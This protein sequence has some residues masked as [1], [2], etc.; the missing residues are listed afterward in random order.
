MQTIPLFKSHFSFHGRSILTLEEP[1][2]ITGKS[3]VSVFSIAKDHGLKE[4]TLVDDTMTGYMQA[5]TN[6]SKCGVKLIFGLRLTVTASMESKNE[7]SLKTDSKIAIFPKNIDG[8]E[9]L[10]RIFSKAAKDGFYYEPRIDY[11]NLAALWDNLNL[12][13]GIPF[14]DSFLFKNTLSYG[15]CVPDFSFT[16]PFFFTE[17]NGLPFD[18]IIKSKV[19][20]YAKD[21]YEVFHAKSIFYYQKKDFL[22]YL[23]YKCIN[24]RTTLE[25]PEF[26][27]MTSDLFCFESFLE[28]A[29]NQNNQ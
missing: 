15:L 29:K 25:K 23:T 4:L 13:L 2:P 16:E 8:Q 14:Y 22:A 1:A 10:Y 11:K 24:N 5:M 12:K 20:S 7:D 19:L 18:P 26:S 28:N 3:P 17:D 9:K 27:H 6:A 21:D